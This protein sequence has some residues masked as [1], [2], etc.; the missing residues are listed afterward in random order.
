MG[1][2]KSDICVFIT[3]S[4]KIQILTP[5]GPVTMLGLSPYLLVSKAGNF[6]SKT[7]RETS[8]S[9]PYY[10]QSPNPQTLTPQN[11]STPKLHEG[12][13]FS[14]LSTSTVTVLP[15]VLKAETYRFSVIPPKGSSQK[16]SLPLASVPNSQEKY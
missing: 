8:K 4:C 16:Y 3:S 14:V 2:F 15:P 1:V 11:K 7:E 13:G 12:L 5:T 10:S 6:G 9:S